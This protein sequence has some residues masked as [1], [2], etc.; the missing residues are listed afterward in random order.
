MIAVSPQRAGPLEALRA[1]RRLTFPVLV[2]AGN[3]VAELFGIRHVLPE[4]VREVYISFGID[5]PKE[6]G[7][8]SWSLPMPARYVLDGSGVIRSVAADPDYTV[9][10]EAEETL[11]ALDAISS[12]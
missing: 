9:R 10:P 6:N 2:D 11:A 1:E 5:L 8:R 7:D 4:D 12:A 3:R